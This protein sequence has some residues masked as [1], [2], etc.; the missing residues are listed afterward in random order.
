MPNNPETQTMTTMRGGSAP[1]AL[2]V[3]PQRRPLPPDLTDFMNDMF[4]GTV[5]TAD[6]KTYDLSGG[7]EWNRNNW[8]DDEEEG[9]YYY[10]YDDDHVNKRLESTPSPRR[11]K[12]PS[13]SS[14]TSKMTKEWLDEARRIV[15]SSPSRRS[16]CD[17]PTSSTRFGGSPRFAAQG[18][19]A[20][21]GGAAAASLS[22]RRDPLSRSARR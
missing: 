18:R 22:D 16:V 11:G 6:P 7:N 10:Y 3:K 15:A 17:S 4:F 19:L 1:P 9:E 20:P 2:V 12:S 8:Y 14:H 5:Q 21:A 13:S